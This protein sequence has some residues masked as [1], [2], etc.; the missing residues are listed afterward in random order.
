ML[1]IDLLFHQ[2]GLDIEV[3]LTRSKFNSGWNLAIQPR[4][5]YLLDIRYEY[6][7]TRD[8]ATYNNANTKN[9]KARLSNLN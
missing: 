6:L 7:Y 2:V 9:I 8:L 5:N 4:P 3:N 1:Y